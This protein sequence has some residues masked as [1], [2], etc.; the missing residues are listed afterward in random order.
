[1]P[2]T[3]KVTVDTPMLTLFRDDAVT[4]YQPES[5]RT[6]GLERETGDPKASLANLE[7][8][9]LKLRLKIAELRNARKFPGRASIIFCL[10]SCSAL[11]ALL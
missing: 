9:K 6:P 7:R 3:R 11:S 10:S 8:L 5:P 2:S 1:M 4:S